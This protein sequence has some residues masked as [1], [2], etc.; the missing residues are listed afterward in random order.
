MLAFLVI[1]L[2]RAAAHSIRKCGAREGQISTRCEA[3]DPRTADKQSR[4]N[5]VGQK[6]LAYA[7]TKRR[8]ATL[9]RARAR[10]SNEERTQTAM[11]TQW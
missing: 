4:C 8:E 9:A 7:R 3:A 1:A 6:D 11:I 2:A 5:C 10:A